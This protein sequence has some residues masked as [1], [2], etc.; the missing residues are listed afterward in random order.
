M[1]ILQAMEGETDEFMGELVGV[2]R[3]AWAMYLKGTRRLDVEQAL[4]LEARYGCTMEWIFSDRL[5]HCSDEFKAN[6]RA[7]ERGGGPPPRKKGP[8][9]KTPVR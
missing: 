3:Q 8:R 7:I 9:P 2:S 1:A 4:V 5:R 6:L